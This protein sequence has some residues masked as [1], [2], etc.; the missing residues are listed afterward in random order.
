[1]A[2]NW[3]VAGDVNGDGEADFLLVIGTASADPI[4]GADFLL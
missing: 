1:V 2:G 4:T 3:R